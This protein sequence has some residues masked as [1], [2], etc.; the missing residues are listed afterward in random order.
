MNLLAPGA[1]WLAL[2]AIPILLL[3]ML[4]LRRRETPI[5]SIQLWQQVLRDRQSNA[6]W[7]RLRRQLLLLLQLLILASLIFALAR[8]A[9]PV[10]SLASGATLIL[11]DASASMNALDVAPSR[12]AAAR[13]AARDQIERLPGGAPVTLILAGVQPQLLAS[14]ETD[15]AVLRQALETA[16]AGQGSA[17]WPAAFSLA[18]GAAAGLASTPDRPLTILLI[19]DGGLPQSGLPQLPGEVRYLAI[20]QSSANLA[21]SALAVRSAPDGP[22]IF[23]S[24][25]NYSGEKRRAI[26]SFYAGE[27]LFEARQIDVTAGQSQSVVLAGLPATPQAYTAR[28][29]SLDR[30]SRLDDL[31]LD[32]SAYAVYQ[33]ASAGKTLLVTRGNLFLRQL[34]E[35]LPGVQSFVALPVKDGPLQI[36]KG[37]YDLYILDGVLPAELPPGHLLIL[38]PP[39]NSLFEVTGTFK[40]M[41]GM[42]LGDHPLT[43]FVEWG[44]VHILQAQ[45]VKLPDWGVALIQSNAG[46]LVFVGESGSRRVAVLTFDLHDSDLPLQTAFPILF[47]NLFEYLLQSSNLTAAESGESSSGAETV[48]GEP[49]EGLQIRPGEAVLIRPQLTVSEI[50]VIAPDGKSY[51]LPPDEERSVFTQS[52]ALGIY[53]VSYP[54]HP[55]LAP[56]RFAVNLF[57]PLESD[58]RP[59]GSVQIGQAG[60]TPSAKA[61][62]GQYEVWPWIA[63]LALLVLLLEWWV[64]QR[65]QR[66]L[67]RINDNSADA[68]NPPLPPHWRLPKKSWWIKSSEKKSHAEPR[69]RGEKQGKVSFFSAFSMLHRPIGGPAAP[70]EISSFVAYITRRER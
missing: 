24:V 44:G 45:Q 58:L 20:G 67:G 2:L 18:A 29:S 41:S 70:R 22:Q 27:Q 13:A 61:A 56:D 62:V 39:A 14:A 1:L 63:A 66:P 46:P 52:E 54:G 32:D 11:L 35:S 57:S 12:F 65:Q 19:S 49:T 37:S 64:Y 68:Q 42:K 26:L 40:D 33:P 6:P 53:R 38:N 9:F 34:L 3:Y 15:R 51:R 8:P 69:S 47:S 59:A 4:K 28:L 5:S 7:Q 36:P 50:E 43:R 55:E 21:I 16:Q 25:R 48:T 17:D 10:P 31:P 23:A 30:A 60:L